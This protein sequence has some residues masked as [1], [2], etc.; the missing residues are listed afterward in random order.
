[1]IVLV[2]PARMCSSSPCT[3]FG[4]LS[5]TF[6]PSLSIAA[7][8]FSPVKITCTNIDSKVKNYF[9]HYTAENL[10]DFFIKNPF[11]L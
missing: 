8:I 2:E 11:F 6:W 1:M 10:T 4:Q 9:S 3:V 7:A 5:A